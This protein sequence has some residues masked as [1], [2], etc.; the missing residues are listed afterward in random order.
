MKIGILAPIAWH[1]PPRKYGPW[2][3]VA[4]SLA[5]GLASRGIDVTLFATAQ[6]KTKARLEAIVPEPYLESGTW[7]PQVAESLHF[8]HCFEHAGEFDLIHNHVNCYP[9]AFAPFVRTPILTTL[10]GSALLEPPTH[11]LY[12]RFKHLPYVSISDAERLGLPELNYVATIYNGVDLARFTFHPG[13]GE[14][15]VFL[16]RIS[17]KKGTHLAIEIARRAGVRL[18]VAAYVPEDERGYF[19]AAVKPLLGG[20]IEFVGEVGPRERDELL[21]QALG[22]L[23]PTTVPEPFG[24]TLVEAQATGTPVIG[25]DNGSVPEVVRDGETGFVVQDVDQAVAAVGRLEE[26][27][28]RR[29]REW[30][31]ERFTLEKMVDGYIDAYRNVIAGDQ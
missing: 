13:A 17:P 5:D 3:Q 20:R 2:E 7:S 26:I 8:S 1:I 28:R 24:L 16:G 25:F 9:L 19:D 11:P 30:V 22:L 27:D 14:Y 29:C 31:E 10:H 4:G 15:L 23:H 12:L 21:G 6:A 18:K